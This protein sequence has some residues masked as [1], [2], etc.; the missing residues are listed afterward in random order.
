MGGKVR[1]GKVAMA[2]YV[3]VGW[4]QVRETFCGMDG[5]M[6]GRMVDL[7]LPLLGLLEMEGGGEVV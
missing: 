3:A 1:Y 7:F 5:W 4:A 2:G 6:G